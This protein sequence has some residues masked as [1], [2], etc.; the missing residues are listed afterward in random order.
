MVNTIYIP[1]IL[2]TLYQ[3]REYGVNEFIE[4]DIL[5][6]S[7]SK[8]LIEGRFF[9][10]DIV[11]TLCDL[12]LL[13]CKNEQYCIT[14]LGV[15]L[16]ELDESGDV[17]PNREQL[18]TLNH[19]FFNSSGDTG[20]SMVSLLSRFSYNKTSNTL[21]VMISAI[22]TH[23]IEYNLTQVFLQT[24]VLYIKDRWYFVREY[25]LNEVQRLKDKRT[26]LSPE[27]LDAILK[28]QR[29]IG[30]FAEDLCMEYETKRLN[31]MEKQI[32]ANMIKQVSREDTSAGYDIAS[33]NGT[34]VSLAHDRFIEV[35]ATSSSRIRFY[36]TKRERE[37]ATKLNVKYWLYI[38]TDCHLDKPYW[39]I[40]KMFQNPIKTVLDDESF[41]IEEDTLY[42][43]EKIQRGVSFAL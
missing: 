3:M 1:E 31:G 36:W 8:N 27:Y 42:I 28:V 19:C 13:Q 16:L 17:Y 37:V 34:S 20:E 6:R 2:R 24:G 7:L 5:E 29:E 18:V 32:Q 35:K 25:Y 43:Y 4:I 33:F 11:P 30:D 38:F 41:E 22:P 39:G 12:Y 40:P 23:S 14:K 9:S 21:R 10:M 26:S 15:Y